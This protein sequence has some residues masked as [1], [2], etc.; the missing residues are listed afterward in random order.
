MGVGAGIALGQIGE[1]SEL[2][3]FKY[4]VRDAEPAHVGFLRRR[5]VEQAEETPA[6][7]VV[8]F[9]CF[10]SS[11]LFLQPLVSVERV[12]LAFEFFWI[13]KLAAGFDHAV[14]RAQSGGIGPD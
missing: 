6:E 8:G 2:P 4:A 10:V 3:S 9:R 13:G 11:R 1:A 12:K 14:L 7:I 5:A